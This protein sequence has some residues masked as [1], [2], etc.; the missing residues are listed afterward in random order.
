MSKPVDSDSFTTPGGVLVRCRTAPEI[1][2]NARMI[3]VDRLDRKAR[4]AAVVRFR[5]S[6]A[7]HALGHGLRRPAA[8]ALGGGALGAGHGAVRAR[9][10]V[11]AGALARRLPEWDFVEDFAIDADGFDVEI[12]EPAGRFPEEERSRQPSVFSLARAI[13]AFLRAPERERFLGLYGA[14][15]YNL[16]FQFE[17]LERGEQPRE[18]GQRDLVLY[19]PDRLLVGR[20]PAGR[21]DLAVL[22]VRDRRRDHRGDGAR[23]AR[24]AVPLRALR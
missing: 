5:V 4:R 23:R 13:L 1:Y 8:G 10:R 7:L 24:R 16:A 21:G 17:P 22:G 19:L 20:P 2:E 9:A 12:R 18:D 11:L 3:L 6:R 15:G 14:F